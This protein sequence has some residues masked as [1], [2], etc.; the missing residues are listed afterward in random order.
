MTFIEELQEDSKSASKDDVN[1]ILTELLN[2]LNKLGVKE[3]DLKSNG[4]INSELLKT[5]INGDKSSNSNL[6]SV[7]EK[8]LEI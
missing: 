8:V 3:E 1:D 4:E 6:S 5:M 7:M 2:L